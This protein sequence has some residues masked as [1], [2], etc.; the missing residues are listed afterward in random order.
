MTP[1]GRDEDRLYMKTVWIRKSAD[2]SSTVSGTSYDLH[3]A[4][5]KARHPLCPTAF[6]L[7][8]TGSAAIIYI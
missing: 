4:T 3:K 2:G 1:G 7:V 6:L 8:K 5:N